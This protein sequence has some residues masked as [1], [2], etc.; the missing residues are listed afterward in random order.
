MVLSCILGWYYNLSFLFIH[1]PTSCK[2]EIFSSL[3]KGIVLH[4]IEGVIGTV[5]EPLLSLRTIWL[6]NYLF[7]YDVQYCFPIY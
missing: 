2:L 3:N 6:I 4:C 1:D 7:C 5:S